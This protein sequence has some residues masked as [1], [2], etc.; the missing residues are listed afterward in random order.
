MFLYVKRERASWFFLL[1]HS[2]LVV[3][4]GAWPISAL[5]GKQGAFRIGLIHGGYLH[6]TRH[7]PYFY[8]LFG[9]RQV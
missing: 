7:D 1:R 2:Y 4:F 9:S 5:S 3:S 6:S 8:G